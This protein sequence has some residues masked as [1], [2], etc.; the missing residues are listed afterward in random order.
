MVEIANLNQPL[1]VLSTYPDEP[2]GYSFPRFPIFPLSYFYS[3][4]SYSQSK[5]LIL[6]QIK[7]PG[8]SISLNF[9]THPKEQVI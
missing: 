6:N 5:T 4:M 1:Q 3:T 8:L 2:G 9:C 7:D